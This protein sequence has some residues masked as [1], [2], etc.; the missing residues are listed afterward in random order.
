[1]KPRRR[2]H[3]VSRIDLWPQ[4]DRGAWVIVRRNFDTD[5]YF[6]LLHTV[7]HSRSYA[8]KKWARFGV[9]GE[10]LISAEWKA[11]YDRGEVRAVQ[12]REIAVEHPTTIQVEDG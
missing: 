10:D 8:I 9:H 2:G 1:M 11:A 12:L 5:R 7:A 4:G 6:V 3:Y